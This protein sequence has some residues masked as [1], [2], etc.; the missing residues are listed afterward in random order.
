M[1]KPYYL[2]SRK[3]KDGKRVFY[4]K[5][6]G[7]DGEYL[8]GKSTGETDE[9][10]AEGWA[11]EQIA[12]GNVR[13]RT[14]MRFKAYAKDFF[15]WDGPYI[16]HLRNR[17]RKIGKTHA[18]HMN[19][20][21]NNRL[22]DYFGK[23]KL[24][25]ITTHDIE[26]WQD[27]MLESPRNKDNDKPYTPT[28]INHA[29]ICLRTIM[30]QAV[31][32]GYIN[33][34]PCEGI[35]KLS[36]NKKDRGALT[37]E[38]GMKLF[39]DPSTWK[40]KH[41]Y[42][43]CRLSYETGMRFGEVIALKRKYVKDGFISVVHS[44]SE[45]DGLKDP[46]TKRSKRQ[47]KVTKKLTTELKIWMEESPYKKQDDFIFYSANRDKPYYFKRG[48]YKT[49]HERMRDIGISD[50]KRVKRNIVFHSLRHSFNTRM[51]NKGIPDFLIQAYMGHSS[52]VM[53]DN[54]TDVMMASFDDVVNVQ[55]KEH[56]MMD[57]L[58]GT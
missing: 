5:F 16:K 25:E 48:I 14:D 15:D 35:E 41:H 9:S 31:K 45:E 29:L 3:R 4:V 53:T 57:K 8:S 18:S 52:P 17:N 42:W 26:K 13:A 32:E 27:K 23:K 55:E 37:D 30:K 47:L 33:S 12:N 56:E 1:K 19:S 20:I 44:W 46:K 28:S 21:I 6:R 22:N 49:L 39:S 36:N 51:R 24:S 2:Y 43:I 34:N 54:Y 11:I 40:N 7:P 10:S 58:N 50:E 38:E